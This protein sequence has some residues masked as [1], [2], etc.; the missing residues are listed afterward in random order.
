MDN[1][2]LNDTIDM[3]PGQGGHPVA[4]HGGSAPL[5]LA[6]ARD[7]GDLAGM[8]VRWGAG[9]VQFHCFDIYGKPYLFSDRFKIF[10]D[11]ILTL[12]LVCSEYCQWPIWPNQML[13]SALCE[14][15]Q[16]HIW[17]SCGDWGV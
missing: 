10:S 17:F 3:G 2:A 12:I 5:K 8:F 15:M 11:V 6:E 7:F 4:E 1:Y 16:T 14:E 9:V 13:R